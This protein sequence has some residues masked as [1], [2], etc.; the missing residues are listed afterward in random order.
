MSFSTKLCNATPFLVKWA[1]HRGI[2]L[3]IE[4][5]GSLEV[6]A[7][8]M[9]QMLPDQPGYENIRTDMDHF[10]VFLRDNTRTYESQAVESIKAS[11]KAKKQIYDEANNNIRSRAA[12]AGN[13]TEDAIDH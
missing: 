9:S 8:I 2:E 12:Q 4:P 3:I 5:F 7:D 6:S 13:V 11:I 10:G 1:Y